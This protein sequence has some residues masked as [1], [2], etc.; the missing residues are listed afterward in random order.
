MVKRKEVFYRAYEPNVTQWLRQVI[1]PGMTVYVVGAHLG[2][3]VLMI[4]SLLRGKGHVHA[5]EGWAE[6]YRLLA[7]N[8]ACNPRLSDV[9]SPHHCAVGDCSGERPMMAGPSD[10]RHHMAATCDPLESTVIVPVTTLD[11]FRAIKS[12]DP[13]VILL[14]IEGFE[15]EALT[16][17]LETLATCRPLLVVE[18]H[19]RQE[20]LVAW[21]RKHGYCVERIDRRHLFATP[22][23]A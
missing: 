3:H 8:I 10:G 19:R 18:H 7:R 9:I 12:S 5:F 17:S 1:E 16:G 15:Q 13:D 22:A 4:A 6:N 14:D 20:R 23:P 21:L 2:I 11:D